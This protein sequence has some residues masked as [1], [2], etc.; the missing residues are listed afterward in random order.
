MSEELF[1][2]CGTC[3]WYQKVEIPKDK[4]PEGFTPR[5][6]CYYNPPTVFPMPQ[7]KQSNLALA[8]GQQAPGQ[9]TMVPL[10]QRPV[11]EASESACGRWQPNSEMREKLAA[12]DSKDCP[13]GCKGECEECSCGD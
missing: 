9:V 10:M 4:Q 7:Q 1:F 5:G 11:V 8:Q 3:A 13:D 12:L 6:Y 2:G